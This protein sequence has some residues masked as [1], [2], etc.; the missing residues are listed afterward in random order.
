MR[1]HQEYSLFKFS[2]SIGELVLHL[3]LF[4]QHTSQTILVTRAAGVLRSLEYDLVVQV[5]R[6]VEIDIM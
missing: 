6:T 4:M 2:S 3:F 1:S 5:R